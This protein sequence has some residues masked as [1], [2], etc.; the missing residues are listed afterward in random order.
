MRCMS[1]VIGWG[2]PDLDHMA[3]LLRLRHDSVLEAEQRA[4]ATLAQRSTSL[5]DRMLEAEDRGATVT[6]GTVDGARIEGRVTRVAFDHLEL[7]TSSG[8][9]VVASEAI[10]WLAMR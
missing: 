9:T 2:H 7:E 4:A 8:L 1:E 5:F 6:L 3:R 10:T